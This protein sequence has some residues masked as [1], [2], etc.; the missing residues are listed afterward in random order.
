MYFFEP[1]QASKMEL[2]AQIAIFHKMLFP[3]LDVWQVSGFCIPLCF[4]AVKSDLKKI[5]A[6]HFQ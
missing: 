6:L 4:E 5:D 2:L 3:F 1:S